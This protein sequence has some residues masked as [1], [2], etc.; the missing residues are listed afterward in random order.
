MDLSS[1]PGRMSTSGERVISDRHLA[2]ALQ[3][4]VDLAAEGGGYRLCGVSGWAHRID[5][6]RV[7]GKHLDGD[8]PRLFAARLVDR[9][10]VGLP[11]AKETWVCR[12]NDMGARAH[13][14]TSGEAYAPIRAPGELE[15]NHPVY[16]PPAQANALKVIRRAYEEDDGAEPSER[17]WRTARELTGLIDEWNRRAHARPFTRID[18]MEL[19]WLARGGLEELW[20]EKLTQLVVYWR[21]SAA[22]LAVRVLKWPCKSA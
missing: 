5:V 12:A 18:S 10:R 22:G 11:G 17:G 2:A 1:E 14:A 9:V 20:R 7:T 15:E 16:I 6:Q 13:A 21:V 8:L 4:L 19:N 3:F